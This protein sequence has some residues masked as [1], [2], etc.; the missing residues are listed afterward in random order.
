MRLLVLIPLLLVTLVGC[1]E[2]TPGVPVAVS[3]PATTTTPAAP[4]AVADA[5]ATTTTTAGVS[6]PT[7]ATSRK[8]TKQAAA[9]AKLKLTCEPNAP[10]RLVGNVIVNKACPKLNAAKE[11]ANRE[12]A[13]CPNSWDID[14]QR[15]KTSSEQPAS[16]PAGGAYCEGLTDEDCAAT[17][18]RR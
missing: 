10:A 3:A 2:S 18:G 8:A 11:K 7:Q 17:T 13:R 15:C 14:R 16:D 1:S 6:T 9:T 5:A 12:F 4:A